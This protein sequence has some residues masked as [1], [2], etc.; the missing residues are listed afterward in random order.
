MLIQLALLQS[1]FHPRTPS[2]VDTPVLPT[3]L[4]HQRP[5]VRPF[6]RPLVVTTAHIRNA[7]C[8]G[9][10]MPKGNGCTTCNASSS[11]QSN[12]RRHP[13][14]LDS[15]PCLDLRCCTPLNRPPAVTTVHGI[16]HPTCCRPLNPSII[17]AYANQVLASPCPPTILQPPPVFANVHSMSYGAKCKRNARPEGKN[18]GSGAYCVDRESNPGL[19]D[20]IPSRK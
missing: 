3:L 9:A 2:V 7:W 18:E 17:V 5:L 19:A 10:D 1:I 13:R 12:C 16:S 6:D 4:Y 14:Q 20:V 8:W 11:S 15:T